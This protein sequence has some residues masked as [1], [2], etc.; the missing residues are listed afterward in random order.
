MLLGI[1]KNIEEL[2]NAICLEELRLIIGS[3]R[4][5]ELRNQKFHAAIQGIDMDKAS[6]QKAQEDFKRVQDRVN[7]RLAGKT[8]TEFHLNSLGFE[9]EKDEDELPADYETYNPPTLFE[10]EDD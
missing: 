8:D 1:W 2:E 9:V 5:K 6:V 4:E 10:I 7:A 3:M